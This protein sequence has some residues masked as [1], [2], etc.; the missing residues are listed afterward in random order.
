MTPAMKKWRMEEEAAR[1]RQ[2]S[3]VATNS[4][5]GWFYVVAGFCGGHKSQ[6]KEDS[7]NIALR[8]SPL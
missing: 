2:D 7:I 3:T 4:V 1:A 6:V 5:C 8:N